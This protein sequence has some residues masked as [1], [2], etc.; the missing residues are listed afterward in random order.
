MLATFVRRQDLTLAGELRGWTSLQVNLKWNG[1]GSWTVQGPNR[2]LMRRL[3]EPTRGLVV[4]DRRG[5]PLLSPD[6]VVISGD[7]EENGPLAWAAEGGDSGP[8][9]ITLAGGDDLAIV[10]DELAFPDPAHAVSGQTTDYDVRSGAAETVIKGFVG[11]NVGVGRAS[12]RA[13]A[14]VPT[15]RTVV[16]AP[17]LGRGANVSYQARF[18]P[19]LEVAVK[20]AAA[21]GPPLGVRVQQSGSDL[22]F[23]VYQPL[24]RSAAVR[25]SRDRRNLRGYTLTRSMPTATHVV[26]AGGGEGA[27]RVFRE[28]KDAAA[29]TEWGRIV[30][31]FVDQRQTTDAGEL[32]NAGDEALLQGTR[33]GAL[34][35]TAVDTPRMRFGRHFGLGDHVAV[36]LE[37]GVVMVDRVTAATLSATDAG[38]QP[39]QITI[40]TPDRDPSTSDLYGMVKAL[41]EEI[42]ALQRR[43]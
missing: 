24:D 36:E 5:V 40:G 15:A 29:A 31:T 12:A 17:D 18:D 19:L 30:R 35:V 28:R 34:S 33:T 37:T 23:D 4:V 43:Y 10:A 42:G 2:G 6:D 8:G 27:A 9:T 1:V 39:T 26:V 11:A 14:A 7:V 20:M 32:D 13:D 21:A 16:I 25:F 22:V 41:Q 38:S 3:M